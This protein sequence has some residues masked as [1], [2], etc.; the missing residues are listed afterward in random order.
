M[1]NK[2]PKKYVIKYSRLKCGCGRDI[3]E[4]ENLFKEQ[5]HLMQT[6]LDTIPSPIYYKNADGIYE[7]CNKAFEAYLGLNRKQVIGKGV[8]DIAPPEYAAQYYKMDADLFQNPGIQIYESHVQYADGSAHDVIFN[9]ATYT[10]SGSE[11]AGLVGVI[12]DITELKKIEQKLQN[13]TEQLQAVLTQIVQAMATITETRDMYTAGHQKRVSELCGAIATELKLPEDIIR[14]V[15]VAGMLHD[16]GKIA[17]PAEILTKPAKLTMHETAL[18][19]EHAEAGYN[20]L[21][22]IDFSWP[23]AEIIHQHHERIDGSGYPNKLRGD[24]MLIEAQILAVA[25]VVEAMS[26]HRPY[27]PSLGIVK[28]ITEISSNRGLLY[29]E[30]VVAACVRVFGN[31]QFWKTENSYSGGVTER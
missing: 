17:I 10:N 8:Y 31:G 2:R 7:G 23:I 14:S 20:I 4:R 6:L 28:A 1:D 24:D 15:E 27:R 30:D 3:G 11:L 21:K 13:S 12:T 25:D 9:K 22:Q 29:N 5:L 26:S 16:I 19:N 18:V